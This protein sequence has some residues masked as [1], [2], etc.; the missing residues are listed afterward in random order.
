LRTEIVGRISLILSSMGFEFS[1]TIFML[2]NAK[3]L[4]VEPSGVRITDKN[5]KTVLEYPRKEAWFD[6]TLNT[7]DRRLLS[8]LKIAR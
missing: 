8:D 1:N 5:G 2:P 4:L 3:R 6:L 7:A